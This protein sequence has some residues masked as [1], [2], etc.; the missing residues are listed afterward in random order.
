MTER[1]GAHFPRLL[2]K[3][4]RDGRTA[5]LHALLLTD[6]GLSAQEALTAALDGGRADGPVREAELTPR[7]RH[8]C[9]ELVYGVL[10]AEIRIGC[11][12]GRVLPRPERLPILLLHILELGAYALLFQERVPDHA[13]VHGAVEQAQRLFGRSLARV[14]NGALRSIQRFGS[15]VDSPEFYA[16]AGQKPCDA[17]EGLCRYYS[18]PRWFV[19]IWLAAY[20]EENT[21]LLMRRSSARPWIAL[22]V[23]A[24]HPLAADLRAALCALAQNER[25]QP[26]GSW[27]IAF[28]PGALPAEA[29][30][31]SVDHWRRSGA[32]SFQSAG[33]QLVLEELGLSRWQGRIWDACAG[34]GGKSAALLEQGADVALSTDRAW[35]RLRHLPDMCRSLGLPVPAVC[36]ADACAPPLRGWSGHILLDA[37]CSGL[38][39]LSRRP[40]IRRA[41]RRA[42][43]DAEQLADLQSRLLNRLGGLLRPG[44]ELAYI[45]CTLNPAEN[46]QAVA[47]LLRSRP[48]LA[49]LRQ[50]QTPHAHPWLEGMYG[51]LLR[52]M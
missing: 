45:T 9:S 30:G 50:W 16:E 39:V 11:L 38:G 42:P 5:A 12:L 21:R 6:A 31:V 1:S 43:A 14:A 46:E 2:K 29:L 47:R 18:L 3:L 34:F 25:A 37:P 10:R 13:A 48:E 49:L 33:S 28:A 15:A 26:V 24:R 22:R 19:D 36:L 41:S 51:A 20:G 8:L 35:P 7:E 32:L 40:D 17:W 44:R 23:N 52:R 4:P 27:G